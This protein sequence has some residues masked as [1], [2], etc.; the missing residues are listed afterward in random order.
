M[1]FLLECPNCG[2]RNV[3]E[4]RFGGEVRTRPLSTTS[5]KEWSHYVYVRKNE[6]GIQKEWW[7]HR[8]G[9]QKW[10]FAVRDTRTNAVIE[11]M[12]PEVS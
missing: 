9:C 11:T 8:L 1:G 3:Y 12:W 10:F 2:K 6:A 5:E 7:Y 4:F